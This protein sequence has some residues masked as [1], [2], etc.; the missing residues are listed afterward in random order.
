MADGLPV[1][2]APRM[3]AVVCLSDG[4]SRNGRRVCHEL[5]ACCCEISPTTTTSNAP[6]DTTPLWLQ[7]KGHILAKMANE[8]Q[9]R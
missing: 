4:S 8:P 7:I 9:D 3:G 2:M 1:W 6:V 5:A